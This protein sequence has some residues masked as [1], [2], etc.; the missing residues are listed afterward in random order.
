[1][2]VCLPVLASSAQA[3]FPGANGKIAFERNSSDFNFHVWT[4]NPDGSGQ[5]NL[6]GTD[7]YDFQPAWSPDGSQ[8]AFARDAPR[9]DTSGNP[10]IYVIN[11]DGSALTRITNGADP[12]WSPDGSKLAFA[13]GGIFAG[14]IYTINRDSSVE[15]N[16]SSVEFPTADSS[17]NWSPDGSKI[18][19]TRCVI[20]GLSHGSIGYSS[21]QIYTMNRDGSNQTNVSN[22]TAFDGSPNWSPDGTRIV[23]ARRES[24]FSQITQ[25]YTMNADG[26][27]QTRISTDA[28]TRDTAAAWSPD[29]TEIVF[30]RSFAHDVP[31]GFSGQIFTMNL[32]GSGQTNL[33]NGATDDGEPDWQPVR[34]PQRSDYK[35]TAQFC[36]AERDF[37]GESRF[38]AKYGGGANAHGK[39]VSGK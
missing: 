38:R 31:G 13:R 6:S 2:L 11:A 8:V 17:P 37:L 28:A 36:K 5:A 21:C 10:S 19:F 33:S 15:T 32:D 22:G 14:Q 9:P 18:V 26:T 1:V 12:A 34:G 39:C 24:Q 35:N 3:T 25:I 4:M 7:F 27:N 30:E 20:S 16:L 29:G 23:F